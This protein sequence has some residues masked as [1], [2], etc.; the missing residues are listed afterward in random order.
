MK[1]METD[2]PHN[3]QRPLTKRAADANTGS[4]IWLTIACAFALLCILVW[5]N[6]ILDLPHYF[7]GAPRTTI[8]WREAVGETAML[9]VVGLFAVSM[10]VRNITRRMQAEES[11]R[12][13]AREWSTTW[14]CINDAV[15]IINLQ[16]KFLRCNKAMANL[17][18]KPLSKI[19]NHTCWELVHGTSEP[20]EGCPIVRMVES[21]RRET[22]LLPIGDRWLNI[23]ADPMMDEDGD[24]IGGVHIISDVTDHKLAEEALVHEKKKFEEHSRILNI[25]TGQMTDMVYYKNK[26][27][28]YI[29]SSKPYCDRILKC[30]QEECVGLTDVEIARRYRESGHE[31]GFGEICFNSDHQT[32]DAGKPSQFLETA[33]VDGKEIC[34]E[35]YK[36]PIFDEHGD[37]TGIVGCSRDIAERK[38][39]E[40]QLRHAHKMAAIGTLAGGIAHNFNNIL[41]G[42]MGYASLAN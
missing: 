15:S 37:F 30:S 24:L 39:L 21:H 36:T 5:L 2:R 11:L 16:G 19:I 12:A 33:R 40:R 41:A 7:L 14:D 3:A 42:I 10:L 26:K 17:L 6:E 23:T 35:V 27:F 32:R 8:N 34:L 1:R 31:Q 18:G 22:L 25:M 29:F 4:K 20:I 9:V 38:R 28:R 13:S